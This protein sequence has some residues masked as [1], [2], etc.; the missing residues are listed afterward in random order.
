M[1]IAAIAEIAHAAGALVI[2]DNVFATPVFSRAVEL[3]ADVV[4]YSTTKHVDGG[5]RA[6]GA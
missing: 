5:G 6:L 2:A 3:G 1:D 4:V